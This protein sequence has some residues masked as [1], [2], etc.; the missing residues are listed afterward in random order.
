MDAQWV[1]TW[2]QEALRLALIIS[3]PIL[4]TALLAGIVMGTLQ[5][6]MQLN[7]ASIG[8]IPRMIV[9]GLAVVMLMPWMIDQWVGFTTSLI[10]S[11]AQGP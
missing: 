5:T 7:E 11:V 8:Q 10:G 3:L 6:I 2:T 9:V 4:A 1:L